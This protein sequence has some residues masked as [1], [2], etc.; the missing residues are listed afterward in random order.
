MTNLMR[1]FFSADPPKF[2][3][4]INILQLCLF[5]QISLLNNAMACGPI[6]CSIR[7]NE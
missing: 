6:N 7:Q 1:I 2:S 4:E 5:A 3:T